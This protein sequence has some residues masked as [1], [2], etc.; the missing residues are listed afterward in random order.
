MKKYSVLLNMPEEWREPIQNLA[1]EKYLS[2]AHLMREAI[3]IAFNLPDDH[4]SY[5]YFRPRVQKKPTAEGVETYVQC[6]ITREAK[7]FLFELSISKG[8][9]LKTVAST[10]L[11]RVCKNL[12]SKPLHKRIEAGKAVRPISQGE[13]EQRGLELPTHYNQKFKVPTDWIDVL[14]ANAELS[15]TTRYAYIGNIL[16][17]VYKASLKQTQQASEAVIGA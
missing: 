6:N 4:M 9:A 11:H 8:V 12:P 15:G 10:L 3:Q 7:E 17:G 5:E 14:D 16:E 2:V 1:N 13:A